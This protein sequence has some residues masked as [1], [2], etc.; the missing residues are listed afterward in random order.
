MTTVSMPVPEGEHQIEQI[1]LGA[2]THKDI[3]V[4]A[5]L[6]VTGG[7]VAHATFPTTT[8]GYQ[9][10]VAWARSLGE[11]QR[12][13]VEGTGSYGA[14][15]A[16][17]L[18]A[19]RFTVLEVNRPNRAVRR[20]RGK[21]DAIDA[22]N[23]ARAVLAGEANA[24]PKSADGPVEMLRVFKVAKDSAIKARTQS[25]NQLKALLV[26]ANPDLRD[27]L[28]GLSVPRLIS[29][30]VALESATA[31]D[32]AS[33]MLYTLRLLAER[34]QYLTTEVNDLSKRITTAVETAAP[35]LLQQPG[36]GPD[37]A[38]VLL[39]AAGRAWVKHRLS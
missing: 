12:A 15:L 27:R 17:Y 13:G 28:A 5:V 23:A 6:T 11:V 8:S 20:R 35:V 4:A 37:S 31:T 18:Q 21:N 29:A 7:V 1:V 19:E 36:I 2:D 14:A 39:I 10:L 24:T 16:R 26:S 30:C 38:A 33:V 9:Q 32:T 34:I 22:E 25:I 3:H